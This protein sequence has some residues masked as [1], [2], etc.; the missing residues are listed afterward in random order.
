M[1]RGKM[2]KNKTGWQN[3]LGKNDTEGSEVL[4]SKFKV[5]A[6]K[7]TVQRRVWLWNVV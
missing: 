7:T 1:I 4:G 6:A 2:I 5:Y 3:K